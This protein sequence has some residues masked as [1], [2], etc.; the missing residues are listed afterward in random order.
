MNQINSLTIVNLYRANMRFYGV[1]AEQVNS[2]N[3]IFGMV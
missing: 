2:D 3:A 1:Q